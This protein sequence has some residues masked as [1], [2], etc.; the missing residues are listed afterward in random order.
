MKLTVI[1]PKLGAYLRKDD[2][3]YR[4][5]RNR[6]KGKLDELATL[7]VT[8]QSFIEDALAWKVYEE[9]GYENVERLSLLPESDYKFIKTYE[10]DNEDFSEFLL[11]YNQVRN[12][13]LG[14]NIMLGK[15]P[16]LYKDFRG[17]INMWKEA[18]LKFVYDRRKSMLESFL[19]LP[20]PVLMFTGTQ[21]LC[22]KYSNNVYVGDGRLYMECDLDE[23]YWDHCWYGGINIE[24]EHVPTILNL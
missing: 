10:K 6:I 20:Y 21:N 1:F 12:N 2:D 8:W 23:Y 4:M 7:G 17:D 9:L 19:K 15:E 14:L 24:F 11:W 16:S 3:T 5:Y 13:E 18:R 22:A